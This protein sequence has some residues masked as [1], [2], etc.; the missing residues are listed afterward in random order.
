MVYISLDISL[1][2][3]E[4]YELE[5]ERLCSPTHACTHTHTSTRWWDRVESPQFPLLSLSLSTA[6]ELLGKSF[7]CIYW[8]VK[9]S[10][11]GSP[12]L[13]A[14]QLQL[15]PLGFFIS[16]W[17]L[18][19]QRALESRPPLAQSNFSTSSCLNEVGSLRSFMLKPSIPFTPCIH[20][21]A[22]SALEH[23][24]CVHIWFHSACQRHTHNSSG[25]MF[26]S[27]VD[28]WHPTSNFVEL[29]PEG[30]STPYCHWKNI[31]EP[32]HSF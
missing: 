6:S 4:T 3:P 25:N 7:Q 2:N 23:E 9:C 16:H 28:C 13:S 5:R 24:E 12:V 15:P 20:A 11:S 29:C 19:L 21:F 14:P 8:G 27:T 18:I 30:F 17:P 31:L 32:P 26:L 10:L 22:H 1:L